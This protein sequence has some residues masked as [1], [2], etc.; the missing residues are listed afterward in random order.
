MG[1]NTLKSVES[2]MCLLP[3]LCSVVL[4]QFLLR[5][6]TFWLVLCI[7]LGVLLGSISLRY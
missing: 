7:C 1:L 5:D 2:I 4:C 3:N 6:A